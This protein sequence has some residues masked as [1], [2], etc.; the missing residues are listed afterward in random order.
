MY[1]SPVIAAGEISGDRHAE[2]EGTGAAAE[3]QR[4]VRAAIDA[5]AP[6]P[7]PASVSLPLP[8]AAHHEGGGGVGIAKAAF[9]EIFGLLGKWCIFEAWFLEVEAMW[10][11]TVE[12]KMSGAIPT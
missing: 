3:L 1:I 2:S 8:A 6:N 7:H 10:L 12:V 5:G 11:W 4:R 9:I